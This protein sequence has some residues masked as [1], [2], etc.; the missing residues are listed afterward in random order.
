[1]TQKQGGMTLIELVISMLLS[2][3]LIAGMSQIFMQSQKNFALERHLAD[4]TE[5]AVFVLDLLSK[6]LSLAGYSSDGKMDLFLTETEAD[7]K[8]INS[9]IIFNQSE[10]IHGVN[11]ELIYRFKITSATD[12]KNSLCTESLN[13]KAN[14]I[15]KVRIYEN[16][17]SDGIP[18]FYCK[19]KQSSVTEPFNAKPL[20]SQ[21]EKL[22]FR[23]GVQNKNDVNNPDDD[24]FYYAKA[25]DINDWKNVFA[26]KVFLVMRSADNNVTSAKMKY[27]I[28]NTAYTAS[29]NRL[30]HV[31][32]KIIYLQALAQ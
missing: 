29:D 14:D 18:V 5:D 3:F 21:V 23:Y 24:T 30:Y 11:D 25:D 28:E 8:L 2:L 19:V 9:T 27:T 17:D 32:S 12:L 26:V 31:F 1:M 16:K 15:I 6:S 22:E 4:M 10:Y 7:A 20:I 13:F